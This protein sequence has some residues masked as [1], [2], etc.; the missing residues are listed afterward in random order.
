MM[1]LCG[2]VSLLVLWCHNENSPFYGRTFFGVSTFFSVVTFLTAF[3]VDS[4]NERFMVKGFSSPTTSTVPQQTLEGSVDEILCFFYSCIK[5]RNQLAWLKDEKSEQCEPF[6]GRI[7]LKTCSWKNFPFDWL[8][9][10]HRTNQQKGLRCCSSRL[11]YF[12]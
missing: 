2:F 9:G 7:S 5:Q 8:T 3:I 12:G 4:Y 6:P 10:C 1:F 11:N